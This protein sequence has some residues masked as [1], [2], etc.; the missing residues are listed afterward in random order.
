MAGNSLVMKPPSQGAVTGLVGIAA[1]FHLAGAPKGLVNVVT[2]RGSE[3]GDYIT[4]HKHASAISFTGGDTGIHVAKGVA[5]IP[6]QME[7]GG[8]DPAL[9]LPDADLKLAAANIVKGAFSYSGQRCTAVKIAI[10]VT[11]DGKA[12]YNDILPMI[13]DGVK[14][15]KVGDPM[16]EDVDITAVIDKKSADFIES[17]VKDAIEKGAKLESPVG[18]FKRTGNLIEP[19]VLTGVTPDMRL[20]YE[21]QFGPI[22]PIATA[23]SAQ[24]AVDL[25]NESPLGLQ[26]SVFT[27]SINDAISISDQLQAGTI[28]INGAPARGPDHFPFQGF[29]NSG[30]GSQ[31][32]K[33]SLEAMS[34]IKSTV[35]NF[36]EETYQQ[37][38]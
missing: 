30:I 34:K 29:K 23:K 7:L 1:V 35:I 31:G 4:Q 2:G 25:V 22:L 26:A 24:E 5:M 9:V 20:F 16:D 3:I 11:P 15:L 14:K 10:I 13:L 27:N 19:V 28:Q 37:G 38:G 36:P 8:K 18:G 33:W 21:E 12:V 32:V 6:M 17:L